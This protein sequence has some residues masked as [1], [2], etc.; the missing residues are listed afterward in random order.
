[1]TGFLQKVRLI[2][3]GNVHDLL[4][5]TIDLNS[6]SALREEVRELEAALDYMRVEA[7]TQCGQVRT[8]TRE[9]AD[10]ESRIETTKATA[11]KLVDAGHAD[12]A[13]TK[14]AD[15]LRMQVD[16]QRTTENLDTQTKTSAQIDIAVRNIDVKHTEMVSRI[17]TLERLDRDSKAKEATAKALSAAGRLVAGGA[18]LSVDD[19]ESKMRA[20][21]DV[22]SAKLDRAMGDVQEAPDPEHEEKIDDLL[23]SLK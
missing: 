22:A 8:L 13:R 21:N 15:I 5:K 18:D 3:L 23:N 17:R 14:A 4:D 2:T 1:M 11:K 16:L 19:I 12:L 10:L 6:P 20:R 7:A 9:K